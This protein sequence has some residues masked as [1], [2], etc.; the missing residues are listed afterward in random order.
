METELNTQLTT[1]QT[2]YSSRNSS[3]YRGQ[4]GVAPASKARLS[5]I[6]SAHPKYMPLDNAKKLLETNAEKTLL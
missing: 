2:P 4:N 5:S 1:V 3:D 6:T